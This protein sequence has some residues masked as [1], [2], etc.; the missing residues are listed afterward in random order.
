MHFEIFFSAH[1]SELFFDCRWP[2]PFMRNTLLEGGNCKLKSPIRASANNV[3]LIETKYHE[4]L[5]SSQT[6]F[7]K[8]VSLERESLP[9]ANVWRP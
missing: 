1:F 5:R 8:I 6:K 7:P 2:W 3:N 9:Y 4:K